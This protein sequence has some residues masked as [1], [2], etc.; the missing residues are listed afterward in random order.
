MPQG[1]SRTRRFK[2]IPVTAENRPWHVYLL[3]CADGS[4]YTG[5]SDNVAARLIKH[6]AGRG[7]RYTASRTPVTLLYQEKLPDRAAAMRRELEIKRWSKA[8]KE[9]LAASVSPGTP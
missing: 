9:K 5:I 2:R 7:A 8:R 1:H 3:R 6:N 4:L